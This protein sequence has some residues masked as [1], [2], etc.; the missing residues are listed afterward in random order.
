MRRSRDGLVH[1][2]LVTDLNEFKIRR[3]GSFNYLVFDDG[4]YEKCKESIPEDFGIY[5]CNYKEWKSQNGQR[6][7]V[8]NIEKIRSALLVK[9][10]LS[11]IRGNLQKFLNQEIPL[12]TAKLLEGD[13]NDE[14]TILLRESSSSN[15]K[16]LKS[17]KQ[18]FYKNKHVD[19]TPVCKAL[20]KHQKIGAA[21]AQRYNKF[22]FFFD[23]GTGKTLMERKRINRRL[24]RR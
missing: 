17:I 20:M 4:M 14:K 9:G 19:Y 13:V 21:I 16:F 8:G 18:N 6:M 5:V 11:D 23:T 12:S 10:V 3:V 2:D 22:G 7:R 1:Y 15:A 24:V